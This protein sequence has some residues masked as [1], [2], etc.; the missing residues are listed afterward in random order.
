M[1][2][3]VCVLYVN[4]IF[5]KQ[6]DLHNRISLLARSPGSLESPHYLYL[7]LLGGGGETAVVKL[8]EQELARRSSRPGP[9]A[10]PEVMALEMARW[11][12]AEAACSPGHCSEARGT[13][14]A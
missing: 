5:T 13:R 10:G 11:S 14:S 8:L 1:Q 6:S 4:K 9:A 2:A 3:A 12:P 7:T